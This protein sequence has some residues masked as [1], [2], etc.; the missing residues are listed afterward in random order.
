MAGVRMTLTLRQKQSAFALAI[1]RLIVWIF[2]QGWEVTCGDFNRPD[3]QGHIEMSCHYFRLAADLNL[4]IGGQW[5]D[6][7]CPEWEKIGQKWKTMGPF[8]AWGGDFA[9][10][11]LNHMS[12]THEGRK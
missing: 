4:F 7:E 10:R 6:H 9:S 1:A 12:F 5:M 11:D 8:A 3:H 2:E